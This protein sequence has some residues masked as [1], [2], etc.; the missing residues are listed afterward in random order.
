MINVNQCEY[1]DV[2]DLTGSSYGV[3]I[4]E[5]PDF[6]NN[7]HLEFKIRRLKVFNFTLLLIKVMLKMSRRQKKKTNKLRLYIKKNVKNWT[8]NTTLFKNI[9]I[10]RYTYEKLDIYERN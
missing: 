2:W 7:W 6:V 3:L 5:C 4:Q 10:E 9:E 8:S 1:Y